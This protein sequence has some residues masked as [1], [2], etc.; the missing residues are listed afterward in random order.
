MQELL[1][2]D[3]ELFLKIHRGL[4]NDFFDWLMPLLRN[5]YFW[6]PLYVFIVVFCIKQYKK[7]GVLI[8]LGLL[9]TFAIG[10]L[11]SAKLIKPSVSR[12]RPC[13]EVTLTGQIIPRVKCSGGKSFPSTHATNHFAI[14]IFLIGVFYRKWKPILPLAITWAAAI[15]FAQVYVGVHYPIDVISGA[16]LG[17]LVGLLT[18][19]IY[20]K[21]KPFV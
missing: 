15:C 19:F 17:T 5:R 12:V 4:S 20:R 13:R 21:V 9:L 6:I 3:A 2:L 14:A 1:Q 11:I 10:D 16:I 7:Q 8:I 18:T